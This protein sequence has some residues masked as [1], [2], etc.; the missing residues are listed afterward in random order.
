MYP[1]AVSDCRQSAAD[2]RSRLL[3]GGNYALNRIETV[4]VCPGMT[5]IVDAN[6]RSVLAEVHKICDVPPVQRSAQQE[7]AIAN[8]HCAP[9]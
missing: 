9:R 3:G 5:P 2:W 1:V 6:E 4:Y 8:W 7:A